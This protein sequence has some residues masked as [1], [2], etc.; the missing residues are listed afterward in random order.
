MDI[1]LTLPRQLLTKVSKYLPLFLL[2]TSS[3][4]FSETSNSAINSV[5]PP[6]EINQQDLSEKPWRISLEAIVL[7]R[8]NGGVNQ[9]LVNRVEPGTSFFGTGPS[10]TGSEAFNSNQFRYDGSVGPKLSITYREDANRSFDF[11][12][13]GLFNQS[14]SQTIGPDGNWLTMYAPGFWQTQDYPY[15]GMKWSTSSNLNSAEANANQKIS[16]ALSLIAGLRWLNMNDSLMG[17]VTPGDQYAPGWK[18]NPNEP[19]VVPHCGD[20]AVP[21]PNAGSPGNPTFQQLT[22]CANPASSS[23][24][25]FSNFWTT[26]TTNNLMGIQLGV[27]GVLFE[28]GQFSLD[29]TLKAGLY[30]NH[31]TQSSAVSMEKIMYFAN[32]SSNQ[33]AY[34]G[35]GLI[36]LK[37]SVTNDLLIK[38]G[39]QFLWLGNLALA[40]GQIS[41]TYAKNSPTSLS[42]VGVNAGSSVLF[43]GGT[44]GLEYKF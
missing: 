2:C 4:A 19:T 11:T 25:S 3:P 44:L 7:Q 32:S 21:F 20:S 5:E 40:P 6:N 31:A 24:L 43:Q 17:S 16:K 15:Q 41:K 33:L 23:P 27:Q 30:N 13:F 1:Q 8:S 28:F 38:L 37:Y 36:Q 26:K 42:A 34:S 22:N 39:Y 14:S 35:D 12:Y 10:R 29:G 9:S 18:F